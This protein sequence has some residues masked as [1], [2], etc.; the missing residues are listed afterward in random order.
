MGKVEELYAHA[1][2]ERQE[3]EYQEIDAETGVT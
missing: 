2:D 3:L 1:L